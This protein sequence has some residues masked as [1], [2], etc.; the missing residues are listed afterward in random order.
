MPV[1]LRSF[2]STIRPPRERQ[3]AGA[4]WSGSRRAGRS[5]APSGACPARGSA[6]GARRAATSREATSPPPWRAPTGSRPPASARVSTCSASAPR[7]PRRPP[8]PR[9]YVEL[10]ARLAEATP[11]APG[12]RSTSRISP[13][14]PLC[15]TD[16][17]ARCRPAAACRS[18]PR[19][20]PSPTACST[21][22]VGARP[23]PAGRGD[24]PGEPPP[25]AGDA[26]RLAA[27]G[28]PVRL[29]KGAYLECRA[30]SR[31][32][33]ACRP[34]APYAALASKLRIAGADVALATHDPS[35][36][37]RC[38]PRCP[39]AR[40]ECLLGIDPSGAT[41]ARRRLATT[42]A[43]TSPFAREWFRYFMR[44][45]AESQGA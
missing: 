44:R 6:R 23:R 34:T 16:R 2:D 36:A 31:S 35:C 21:S 32:P 17:R 22:C 18:A 25:L 24:A 10:C 13:S 4:C 42:S 7:S 39:G 30:T 3:F 45:R 26:D 37:R 41:T 19:R 20:R 9:G 43:S 11:A 33:G 15:S 14:T 28:V 12:S 38:S 5:S 1:H 40:C 27:A 29:V 8:S